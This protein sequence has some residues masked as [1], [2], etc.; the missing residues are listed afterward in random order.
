MT[1]N[2]TSQAREPADASRQYRRN[3]S[4]RILVV[5]E[6]SNLRLPYVFVLG[7]PG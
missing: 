1:G 3:F 5:D 7:R 4:L 6:D 2:R